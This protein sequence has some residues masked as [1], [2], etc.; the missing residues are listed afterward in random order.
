M[1]ASMRWVISERLGADKPSAMRSCWWPTMPPR[2]CSAAICG[3]STS[4]VPSSTWRVQKGAQSFV[5][6]GGTSGEQRDGQIGKPAR[7]GDG[8]LQQ[9][10]G[11]W[12]QRPVGGGGRDQPQSGLEI[13][14]REFVVDRA[15][16]ARGHDV[17]DDRGE[18]RFL[19][20]EVAVQ[21]R[22]RAARG[23][24]DLID[25]HPVEAVLDEQLQGDGQ[26]VR[27]TVHG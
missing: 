5:V 27:S 6:D 25:A 15:R 4:M 24:D 20:L 22:F 9:L 2:S 14:S 11:A 18:Q 12:V 16:C 1:A 19:G 13:G 17:V 23:G 8:E 21:G 7:F 26:V 10:D 3:S